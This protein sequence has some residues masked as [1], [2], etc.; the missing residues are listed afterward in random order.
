M[1]FRG[2]TAPVLVMALAVGACS[3]GP[4]FPLAGE[5]GID[6]A[7]LERAV[8]WARD[9]GSVHSL[10]VERHGVLVAE[11]YFSGYTRDSLN[12]VWSVTKSFTSTLIGLAVD[13][14]A[15]G[16]RSDGEGQKQD[17]PPHDTPPLRVGQDV[18]PYDGGPPGLRGP[19]DPAGPRPP[20]GL[21][22]QSHV[23]TVWST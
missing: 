7:G 2:W 16:A 8:D 6:A 11:A 20:V 3:D 13:Q 15:I 1:R 21:T 19:G 18:H 22:A 23:C 9:I 12:V 17:G 10:L 4:V 14:G 5:Q